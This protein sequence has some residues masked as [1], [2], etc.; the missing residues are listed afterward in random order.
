[1]GLSLVSTKRPASLRAATTATLAWNRFIPYSGVKGCSCDEYRTTNLE[2]L[3]SVGIESSVI[4]EDVDE[5]KVMADSNLIIVSIMRRGDLDS[6]SAEI[7]VND[8]G[9]HD[10]WDSAINERVDGKFSVKMLQVVQITN[11]EMGSRILTVYLGSSG[12]TAIAVSPSIVSGRVVAIVIFS[13]AKKYKRRN[14]Y[15]LEVL[16]RSLDRVRERSKNTE[17]E[18]F[19][20]IVT[21]NMQECAPGQLLLVDLGRS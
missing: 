5:R 12:W 21:G 6:A 20:D 9:V 11:S 19:L 8:N 7:H 2:F 17:F 16:T 15:F 10:D 1:M 14:L 4:V 18:L 3:S 13:S